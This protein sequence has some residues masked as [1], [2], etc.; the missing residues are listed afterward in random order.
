[1]KYLLRLLIFMLKTLV[2]TLVVGA[3]LM[4]AFTFSMDA[5]NIYIIANDG[6]KMR[7]DVALGLEDSVELTK[8]F[9]KNVVEQDPLL[10]SG[11]YGDYNIRSSDY[12]GNVKW[13]WTW[14]WDSV[15]QVRLEE[16][17]PIIEGELPVEKQ[18]EEQLN[19]KGKILPPAWNDVRYALTLAKIDGRWKISQIEVLEAIDP[20][21]TNIPLRTPEPVETATPT[22]A[23][24]QSPTPTPQETQSAAP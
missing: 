10:Q 11:T 23:A 3:L 14:P 17:V 13:L 24:P 1:M 9:T 2:L 7:A 5:S 12:R 20:L 18:N 19:T 4:I 6:M 22:P 15:A 16:H 21:P 8:F